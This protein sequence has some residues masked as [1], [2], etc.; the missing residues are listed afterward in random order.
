MQGEKTSE[1]KIKI[2][3]VITKG[4]WG[5]AQKY[6]YSLA[7]SLPK[8]K[9]NV[10]VICGAGEIL[11]EKLEKEKVKTFE[12][13]SLKR[14]IGIFSEIKSFLRLFWIIFRE[15]PDVLHLN[16]PK[17]SGLGVIIGR[18]TFVPKII[19][20]VHGFTWNENR[21]TFSKALITFF[22]WITIILCHKTIVISEKEKEQTW[23]MPFVNDNKITLIRNGVEVIKYREKEEARKKL[24]ELIQDPKFDILNPIIWLGTVAELHKNKGYEY[25]ISAVNKITTPFLF[26]I[27]GSGEEKKNLE[28]LIAQNHL[29][30]KVFL[31]GSVENAKELLKAF[32]IFMLTSIK[33]GL[34][35]VILEAGQA[36]LPVIASR[37]GGTPD[38]I[39]NNSTGILVTK[40]KTSEIT[41][42]LEYLIANP[43]KREL[44]GRNL[45]A[46]VEKDF[47]VEQM[48][49]KTV[50]LY[51]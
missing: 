51:N 50:S 39:E 37:V 18:L 10:F 31:V 36:S 44:F 16:S 40:E 15:K 26:F 3:Y 48:L 6:V 27:I 12:I 38:I 25:A 5:G 4:V 33:E 11:K 17:A 42:A 49:E 8:D 24:K 30:E 19:Q 32:D 34:P 23:R 20:T 41:R 21:G 47:S 9:Y 7:T 22:S 43:G 2:C 45:K 29:E 13:K 46:K 1:R 14:D 35:Y 28:K